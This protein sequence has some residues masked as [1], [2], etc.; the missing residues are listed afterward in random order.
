MKA[1]LREALR[2]ISE[3]YRSRV[4][5]SERLSVH[6]AIGIGGEAEAWYMAV[7]EEELKEVF[8]FLDSENI[9][10]IVVGMCGNIL[11]PDSC[12]DAVVIRPAA[13]LADIE[14]D[15]TL[16]TAGAGVKLSELIRFSSSKGLSGFEG[17]VGI[18]ASVG[19]ALSMNASY[20]GS[21]SDRLESMRV[22]RDDG[23]ISWIERQKIDT[24]YRRLSWGG[25]GTILKAVFRPDNDAADRIRERIKAA[26]WEKMASQPLNRKTLGCIFKNPGSTDLAAWQLIDKA[27]MRG[28]M[29]G[30]AKVSEKH[31]N[32]IVN[33]RDATSGDVKVLIR[34]IK[35]TVQEK[36]GIELEEEIRII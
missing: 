8:S 26:L 16:I 33:E 19:G 34:R 1:H 18:P 7:S 10:K 5:F 6:S 36:C 24:G 28:K 20:R 23:R 35:E 3:K 32:F 14:F 13:A 12:T 22:L 2:K 17:L 11:F 30:G 4:F 25:T 21:I 9:S 15:G 29:S 27:G 31:A